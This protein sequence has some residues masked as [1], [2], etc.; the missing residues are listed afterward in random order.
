MMAP[1]GLGGGE[2]GEL[3][4]RMDPGKGLQHRGMAG[5]VSGCPGRAEP[6]R[7]C[8]ESDGE[9]VR[10][11]E[12]RTRHPGDAGEPHGGPTSSPCWGRAKSKELGGCCEGQEG[13][14]HTAPGQ[15]LWVLPPPH[16]PLSRLPSAPGRGG[17]APP[18][19]R[20]PRPWRSLPGASAAGKLFWDLATSL[21]RPQERAPCLPPVAQRLRPGSPSL[22]A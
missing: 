16:T 3:A 7:R 2:R 1:A 19:P 12:G 22:P 9:G 18:V 13:I 21:P 6:P 10:R 15:H 4:A 8:Q 5:W 17:A 11:G 20:S 14:S